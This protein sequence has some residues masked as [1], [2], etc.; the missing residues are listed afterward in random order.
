MKRSTRF[1]WSIILLVLISSGGWIFINRPVF[2]D[3]LPGSATVTQQSQSA[4]ATAVAPTETPEAGTEGTTFIN[5]TTSVP[6]TN[7]TI[8]SLLSQGYTIVVRKYLGS[9][10]DASQT[11][12]Y[13]CPSN[14]QIDYSIEVLVLDTKDTVIY[15]STN[16]VGINAALVGENVTIGNVTLKPGSALLQTYTLYDVAGQPAIKVQVPTISFDGPKGESPRLPCFTLKDAY[17]AP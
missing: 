2:V 7:E 15:S 5:S 10:R 1:F 6:V 14:G 4:T 9:V 17:Y 16:Y 8:D 3:P 11:A 13:R 12:E